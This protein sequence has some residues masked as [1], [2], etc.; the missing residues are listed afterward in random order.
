[1]KRL[2]VILLQNTLHLDTVRQRSSATA[3]MALVGGHY[4]VQGRSK[5]TMIL[6]PMESP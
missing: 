6:V 4:A 1:M 3:E 2:R 5:S